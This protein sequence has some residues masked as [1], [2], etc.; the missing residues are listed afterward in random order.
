MFS[1]LVLLLCVGESR[2]CGSRR[3][4][5]KYWARSRESNSYSADIGRPKVR[6]P[7][8]SRYDL[9]RKLGRELAPYDYSFLRESSASDRRI[10]ARALQDM[11]PEI[12]RIMRHHKVMGRE[13]GDY[14][15]DVTASDLIRSIRRQVS[16]PSVMQSVLTGLIKGFTRY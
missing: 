16:M 9:F 2:R 15:F 11:S 5:R 8:R 12:A 1:L 4:D 7:R 3:H 6:I 14:E 13:R 10:A